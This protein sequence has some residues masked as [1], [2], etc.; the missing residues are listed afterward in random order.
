MVLCHGS[1]RK[2]IQ[3]EHNFGGP[4][5]N[6][7]AGLLLKNQEFQDRY[8]RLLSQAAGSS[9]VWALCLQ[10]SS[11]QACEAGSGCW[12]LKVLDP[13]SACRKLLKWIITMCTD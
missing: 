10:L 7:N 12:V 13:P 1:L 9:E 11:L 2:L 5:Q 6:E 4:V 3:P 8:R